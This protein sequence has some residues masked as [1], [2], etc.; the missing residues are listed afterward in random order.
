MLKS[1]IKVGAGLSLE[2]AITTGAS[3]GIHLPVTSALAE[4][5]E[6]LTYAPAG[7]NARVAA[8][9]GL[10]VGDPVS[11]YDNGGALPTGWTEGTV[12]WVE[13][14]TEE[15]TPGVA[16]ITLEDK[17]GAS[18]TISDTG[19]GSGHY[20]HKRAR[21]KY[22]LIQPD[23]AASIAAVRFSSGGTAT[24]VTTADCNLTIEN[25]PHLF[26][27]SGYTHVNGRDGVANQSLWVTPLENY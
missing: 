7:N 2:L 1:P 9:H 21:A 15:V 16:A 17:D 24:A 22:V 23:G 20:L 14:I 6:I 19:S 5:V 11:L 10:V 25:A 3:A 26:D 12:Y 4:R 13:T 8:G 18:V 27:V